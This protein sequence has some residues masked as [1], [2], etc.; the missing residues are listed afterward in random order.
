[1]ITDPSD[2]VTVMGSI[3][4][5]RKLKH[6]A[7]ALTASKSQTQDSKS[8]LSDSKTLSTALCHPY[9]VC[10]CVCVC[11]CVFFLFCFIYFERERERERERREREYVSTKATERERIPSRLWAVTTEPDAGFN[12]TNQEVMTWVEIK[13]WTLNRLSHPGTTLSPHP[14]HR[15]SFYQLPH[16]P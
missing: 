10:V 4:L 8:H 16:P 7:V 13:S 9:I 14:P 1:M 3:S 11:V 2:I 12:L 15:V 6:W 5:I